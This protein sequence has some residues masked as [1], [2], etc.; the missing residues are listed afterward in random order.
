MAQIFQNKVQNYVSVRLYI[1]MFFTIRY[2][3]LQNIAEF[4]IYIYIENT[5][6]DKSPISFSFKYRLNSTCKK[7]SCDKKNLNCFKPL[8]GT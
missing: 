6:Q 4:Y 5:V 3:I 2:E 8:N 7:L 1:R